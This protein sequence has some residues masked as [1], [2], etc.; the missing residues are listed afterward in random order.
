MVKL[1]ALRESKHQRDELAAA[2]DFKLA[3]DRMEVLFHHRQTQAGAIS[4]LL[5][6]PPAAAAFS[7][8]FFEHLL[9]ARRKQPARGRLEI[10]PRPGAR[11]LLGLQR[12]E[13]P[14]YV[15]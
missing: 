7:L 14:R 8:D 1:R 6:A 3:E 5:V 12:G 15:R 9:I 10:F 2:V 4:N 11:A 13:R